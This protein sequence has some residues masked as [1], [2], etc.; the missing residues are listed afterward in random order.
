[1]RWTEFNSV[2]SRLSLADW[3]SATVQPSRKVF[4]LYHNRTKTNAVLASRDF[5]VRACAPE[6]DEQGRGSISDPDCH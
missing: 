2:A 3:D 4:Y 6:G 1:M 5:P